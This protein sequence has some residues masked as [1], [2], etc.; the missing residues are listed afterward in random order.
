MD[1]Q[2]ILDIFIFSLI[3]T[4]TFLLIDS[5]LEIS[6]FLEEESKIR[7]T[8]DNITIDTYFCPDENCLGEILL[9]INKSTDIVCAFYDLDIEEIIKQLET[10]NARLIIDEGNKEKVDDANIEYVTDKSTRYMHNKFCVF[11]NKT[12]LTGSM[13]PTYNGAEVNRNNI[14]F[15]ESEKIAENYLDKFDRMFYENEFKANDARPP[16]YQIV[17]DNNRNITV[18]TLFCPESRCEKRLLEYMKESKNKILFMT[19]S[20]TSKPIGELLISLMKD[21]INDKEIVVKGIF[22]RFHNINSQWSQYQHFLRINKSNFRLSKSPGKLHN[23]VFIIDDKITITGSYNPSKNANINNDE[24]IVIITSREI[25]EKYINEF[26]KLW[27]LYEED[28]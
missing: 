14:I 25:T 22:D 18:H 16:K 8:Y 24:N 21:E 7:Y 17:R 5:K 13:N 4:S 20:F 6:K 19:F 1:K 15:I 12:V 23:K 26:N 10:K 27:K 3:L 11:D 9:R 28:I 2:R